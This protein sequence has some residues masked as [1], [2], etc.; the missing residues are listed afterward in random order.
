MRCVN[1]YEYE[2]F[3]S[4]DDLQEAVEANGGVL[5]VPAWKVRDAY[6]AER[7]GAQV[8]AN[9]TRELQGRGLG[10]YPT[11]IPD[12][13]RREVRIYKIASP[14]GAV[15]DAVLRPGEPGDRLLRESAGSEAESILSKVRELV[16]E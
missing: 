11:E 5:T 7:L 4:L 10:H 12:R 9:I 16:C 1:Q 13:Q 14:A 2:E 3:E 6:G 15:I 8:R